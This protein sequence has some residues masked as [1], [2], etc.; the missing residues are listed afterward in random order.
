MAEPKKVYRI[1]MDN[2][3]GNIHLEKRKDVGMV[4]LKWT[5]GIEILR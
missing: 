4:T 2:L 1:S 3:L 5:L